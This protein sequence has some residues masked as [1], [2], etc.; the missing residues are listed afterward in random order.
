M[1]PHCFIFTETKSR[2]LELAY[3]AGKLSKNRPVCKNAVAFAYYGSCR[4]PVMDSCSGLLRGA[5]F[6]LFSL[7]EGGRGVETGMVSS[8]LSRTRFFSPHV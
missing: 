6:D 8:T 7:G 4:F 2:A 5:P 3:F 1:T